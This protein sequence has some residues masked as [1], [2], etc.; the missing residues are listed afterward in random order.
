MLGAAQK[1]FK[2]YIGALVLRK[3]SYSDVYYRDDPAIMGWEIANSPVCPGDDSGNILQA[4]VLFGAHKTPQQM[5]QLSL[6][7]TLLW[8]PCFLP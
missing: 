2:A 3:N 7:T 6:F 4:S 1:A 8:S 5:Q